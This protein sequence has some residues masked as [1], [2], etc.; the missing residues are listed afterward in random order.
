[1]TLASYDLGAFCI[2]LGAFCIE[3]GP[4][5]F[6]CHI[7]HFWTYTGCES[8]GTCKVDKDDHDD[9]NYVK[10][11]NGA[12]DIHVKKCLLGKQILVCPFLL[13]FCYGP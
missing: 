7:L 8:K 6:Q 4:F 10:N 12:N 3:L 9:R 1:M 13:Y 2:E 11:E 5:R